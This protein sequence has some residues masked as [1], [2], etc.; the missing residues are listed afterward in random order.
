MH[1]TNNTFQLNL[2]T[3]TDDEDT[4]TYDEEDS[5]NVVKGKNKKRLMARGVTSKEGK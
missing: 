5:T 2:I 4:G 1:I 3:G